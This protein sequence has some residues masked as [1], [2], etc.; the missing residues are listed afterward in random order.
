MNGPVKISARHADMVTE[1]AIERSS[2]FEDQ[3]DTPATNMVERLT[4]RGA[5]K[6][7]PLQ[8]DLAASSANPACPCALSGSSVMSSAVLACP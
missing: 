8:N 3:K 5:E 2:T 4:K 6:T 7:S 1:L